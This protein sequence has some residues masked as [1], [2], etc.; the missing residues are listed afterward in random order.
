MAKILTDN[1]HLYSPHPHPDP[2]TV[3][4]RLNEPVRSEV[5]G[6][7]NDFPGPGNRKMYEKE[8]GYK[9][10]SFE[11]TYFA[12]PRVESQFPVSHFGGN[13]SNNTYVKKSSGKEIHRQ[14]NH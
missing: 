11:Q 9:E 2:H 10:T 12:S 6:I 1:W 13:I 14:R 8:T 5:L 7:T 3:E 4:L